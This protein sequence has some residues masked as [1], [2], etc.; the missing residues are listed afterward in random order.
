MPTIRLIPSTYYLSSTQYL[1]VSNAANMYHNTDN[2][3]H[4]TVTNSRT[5]TTS[6]Y[7]YLRG[8]NFDDIP[9]GAVVSSFS[10]KLKAYESGVS[11]SDSY[12]PYLADGTTAINGSC[13]AITATASVHTFTGITADWETISGYG[14]DFGIRINCRRASRNTT[15]YMYIY[16]AEIEVTYSMPN[17]RTITTTLSGSGT[18]LPSGQSTA[19]DGDEFEL[20]IT[21]TNISDTVTVTLNGTDVTSELEE[22]HSGGS[23]TSTSQTAASFT[24]ELSASGANFYTSSSSTGNYFNYAVGHT[25]ES[26]GSTSTSYNTYVKDNGSNTATGWAW[27]TFNF[28]AI[29]ETAEVQ[30]IEVKCYGA[31]ESTTHDSTHKADMS[32]YSGSELKSNIQHFTSTSNSTVTISDPGEWTRD[33]LQNARLKFEVAYYGGR[34]FGITWEVTYSYGGSLHHYTYTYTVSGNATI[35]VVIGGGSGDTAKLYV[36]VNGSWVEVAAAYKKVN[37]SWVQQ[38]D[39]TSLFSSGINYKK[40]N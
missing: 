39:I 34:L 1:S 22:H 28:S 8:F 21:P 25:A 24:T 33:E 20:T 26:P 5:S 2:T 23:S 13:P 27:Y 37:G 11:T 32:L 30:S 4:A 36:K 38:T 12:K 35:A 15:G 9:S 16:G 18:I 19:Y 29:P 10:V 14:D 3:S 6:Y 7:I 40:G 17:P 31:C